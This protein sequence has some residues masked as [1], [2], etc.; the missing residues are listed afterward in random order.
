MNNTN[1]KKT[2]YNQ[3]LIEQRADP[4]IYRHVDGSY[5]LLH[6]YRSTTGLY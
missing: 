6:L 5:I 2:E 1:Y 4:Y 3:P